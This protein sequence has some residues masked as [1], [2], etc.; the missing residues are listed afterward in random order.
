MPAAQV[1]EKCVF[2]IA[3]RI[4]SP[5]ARAEYLQQI[6]G[7]DPQVL[8]RVVELLQVH[9]Q[10]QSFLESPVVARGLLP[11]GDTI[12][13]PAEQVGNLIG[14]YKLL[15]QIGEGGMGLVYMAE[16]QRPL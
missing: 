16:Q 7:D 1:N 13:Q 10:E 8:G 11:A 5:E 14:P 15:E 9:E 12:D 3:R 6:C 4:D 2:N